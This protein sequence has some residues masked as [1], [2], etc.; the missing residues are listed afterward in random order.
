[1]KPFDPNAKCPKCG[2]DDVATIFCEKGSHRNGIYD[3]EWVWK[4]DTLTRRCERCG[5]ER[6][7][8]PLDVKGNP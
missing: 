7:E 1:M 5:Y 2:C 6:D 4:R 3:C 8:A